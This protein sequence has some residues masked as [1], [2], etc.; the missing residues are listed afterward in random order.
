VQVKFINRS[1]RKVRLEWINVHGHRE[2]RKDLKPGRC[3]RVDT[4]EGHCWV[5]SD[6]KDEDDILLLNYGWF[7]WPRKTNA[8]KE[9][10]VIT[11][12]K[13]LCFCILH[14]ACFIDNSLQWG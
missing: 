11:E 9:R 3:W 12:G 13:C 8:H 5:C 7:Y 1:G 2:T 10:V 4:M 6:P 14:F